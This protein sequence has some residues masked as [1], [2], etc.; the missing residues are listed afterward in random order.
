M[1]E[2]ARDIKINNKNIVISLF[3]II[4]RE[5]G[6]NE[7]KQNLNELRNIVQNIDQF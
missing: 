1:L 5:I 6:L 3:D 4:T 2:F 7:F